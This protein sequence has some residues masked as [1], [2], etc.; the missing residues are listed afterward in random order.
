MLQTRV[1]PVY[2]GPN[3]GEC[4]STAIN[5]HCSDRYGKRSVGRN[6]NISI[7]KQPV[8]SR[9]RNNEDP[10]RS[11]PL[12]GVVDLTL[13]K[14]RGLAPKGYGDNVRPWPPVSP[15]VDAKRNSVG[16]VL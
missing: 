1:G 11:S 2:T 5:I 15:R 8:V 10:F 7:I 13:H 14:K 16:H 9:G 12:N 3:R 6:L 4:C